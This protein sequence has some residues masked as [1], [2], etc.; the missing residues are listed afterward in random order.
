MIAVQRK[1]VQRLMLAQPIRAFGASSK[2]HHDD[3]HDD[4]HHGPTHDYK[5]DDSPVLNTKFKHPS[6]HD[7]DH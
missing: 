1:V 7:V 4:H 6:Q 3:H 2:D 5:Y